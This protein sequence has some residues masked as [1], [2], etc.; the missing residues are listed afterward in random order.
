MA[1]H[2]FPGFFLRYLRR[3][4]YLSRH[5]MSKVIPTFFKNRVLLIECLHVTV[6]SDKPISDTVNL[7]NLDRS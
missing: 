3:K 4:K 1:A 5:V 6:S 2:T 7:R